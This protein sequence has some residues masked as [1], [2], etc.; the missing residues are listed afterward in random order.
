MRTGKSIQSVKL[1]TRMPCPHTLWFSRC[2]D[3]FYT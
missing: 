1:E 2:W 3:I